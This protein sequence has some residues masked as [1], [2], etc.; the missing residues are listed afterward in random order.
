ML[1]LALS[2][3]A[4]PVIAITRYGAIAKPWHANSIAAS[5]PFGA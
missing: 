5:H 3:A 4:S 2:A 1:A